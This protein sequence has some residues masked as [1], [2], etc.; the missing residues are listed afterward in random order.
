MRRST[1]NVDPIAMKIAEL[2]DRE[3]A[4]R[5]SPETTFEQRQEIAAAVAA[6]VAARL[7]L[8]V[9]APKAEG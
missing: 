2:I 9:A 5:C 3:I 1:R 7:G 6:E 4:A 8:G